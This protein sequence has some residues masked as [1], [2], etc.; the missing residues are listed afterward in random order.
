MAPVRGD[1]GIEMSEQLLNKLLEYIDAAI[2]AKS[3]QAKFEDGGLI[4]QRVKM[5][6]R[7]ELFNMVNK[8]DKP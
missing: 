3:E 2:D 4:E 1:G 7:D 8:E 6:V 5:R